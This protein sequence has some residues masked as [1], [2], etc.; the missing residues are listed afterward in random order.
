MFSVSH[1]DFSNGAFGPNNQIN[2]LEVFIMDSSEKADKVI[3][4]FERQLTPGMD[5]NHLIDKIFRDNHYSDRDFTDLD[6][7]RI[8]RKIEA[9]YKNVNRGRWY[10]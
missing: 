3:K 9:I 6:I 2:G 5:P 1:I 10:F 7:N 8:N 4:E